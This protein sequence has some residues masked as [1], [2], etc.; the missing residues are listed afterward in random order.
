MMHKLWDLDGSIIINAGINVWMQELLRVYV[1]FD[2]EKLEMPMNIGL[3][4]E[5]LGLI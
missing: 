1:G 2:Y 5:S 3:G 4:D